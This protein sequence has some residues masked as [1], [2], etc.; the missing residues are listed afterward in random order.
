MIGNVMQSLRQWTGLSNEEIYDHAD[1]KEDTWFEKIA[2]S[3][4]F[5]HVCTSIV[6]EL[7]NVVPRAI[8]AIGQSF[9]KETASQHTAALSDLF[10]RM[11]F[12]KWAETIQTWIVLSHSVETENNQFL[13]QNIRPAITAFLNKI[14]FSDLKDMLTQTSSDINALSETLNTM[15]WKYPAKMVLLCSVIPVVGN[16]ACMV[17]RNTLKHFNE[18][19][20][21]VLADILI[22]IIK[23]FDTKFLA[24]M[25]DELTELARKLHT[26]SA[27]IGEPGADALSQQIRSMFEKLTA[28]VNAN[29][30]FKAKQAIGQIKNSIWNIWFDSISENEDRLSQSIHLWFDQKNQIIRQTSQITAAIDDIPDDQLP[31]AIGNQ[32]HDLEMTEVAEI[33]NQMVQLVLRLEQLTPDALHSLLFQWMESLDDDAIETM[34]EQLAQPLMTALAPIIQKVAPHLI[35]SFCNTID[36]DEQLSSALKRFA[37]QYIGK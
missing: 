6:P 1:S 9:V 25:L 32:I 21:D 22:S 17:A 35:H 29:N 20:P 5:R 26:G 8:N 18:V 27:L 16:T 2:D 37:E 10:Q 19:P 23:E 31:E 34:N 15:L 7:L 12:D 33:I 24:Q 4:S 30:V 36:T 14:D 3:D 11:D 28:H 13:S